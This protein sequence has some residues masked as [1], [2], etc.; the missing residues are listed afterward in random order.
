VGFAECAELGRPP[1]PA[2]GSASSAGGEQLPELALPC[3]AGGAEIEV[4]ALRGPAVVNLW[5]SWCAP[6]RRE[7]PVF[8]RFAERNADGVRVIGVVSAE[9]RAP[10]SSLAADLALSFP[11]LYDRDGRLMRAVRLSALPITLFVDA[12][13]RFHRYS[14]E[15]L[16]E[17]SL[18]GLVRR[19][20]G[21]VP[22]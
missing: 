16:D 15:A 3:Y 14:G 12:R 21:V 20:L 1:E 17:R 2:G 9:D 8:Q 18:D 7:L 4:S 11:H 13:G 6:C 19:H 5:A 22:R 10:A